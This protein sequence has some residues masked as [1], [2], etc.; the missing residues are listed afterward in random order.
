MITE[1]VL[2]DLPQG[3]TRAQVVAGMRQSVP[4]WRGNAELIRK[5]YLYDAEKGQAGGVYLW[6][7]KAAAQRGHDEAWRQRIK[8]MYGS[9]PVIRYFETPFVVDNALQ[10]T[11]EEAA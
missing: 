7:T 2:F 9:V 8:D 1:L 3:I 10:E 6:K 11:I 5:N 4:T